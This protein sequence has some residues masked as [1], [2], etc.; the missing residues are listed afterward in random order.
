MISGDIVAKALANSGIFPRTPQLSI[1]AQYTSAVLPFLT[2]LYTH[3]HWP[4]HLANQRI[5]QQNPIMALNLEADVLLFRLIVA[6][7]RHWSNNLKSIS[8]LIHCV[9]FSIKDAE[10][11][12]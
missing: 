2:V 7:I 8:F 3:T 10:V 5:H 6:S 11:S 1:H 9:Y 4:C 12:K